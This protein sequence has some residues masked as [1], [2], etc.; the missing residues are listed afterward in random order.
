MAKTVKNKKGYDNKRLSA[1]CLQVSLL[2]NAAIPIPEGLEIMS[3]DASE[4]WERELLKELSEE[5]EIGTPLA[6][7]LEKSGAFPEYLIRMSNIGQQTG[8]LD[9]IMEALSVYY[10]K[11]ARQAE[12][13]KNAITYP[14][15]LVVML[16]VVLYVLFSRVMPVF[17]E[18]YNQLGSSLSPITVT[19]MDFGKTASLVA[20]IAVLV[21]LVLFVV[22]Y[23][24]AKRGI[25][26][27]FVDWIMQT[28]WKRSKTSQSI[29]KRRFAS[30][31]A[32]TLKSGLPMDQGFT[33]AEEVI[34]NADVKEK[35]SKC[36]GLLN[37][38]ENY[39]DVLKS[40]GLF[41]SFHI[42][43]IKVG[44]RSGHLDT[45]M[46][47]ISQDYEEQSEKALNSFVSGFEP[48]VVAILAVC[49]GL[50]LLSVMLPL[51]GLLSSIG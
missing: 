44:S 1:F 38:G 7:A 43:M 22:F 3:E 28:V 5:T 14:A 8:N 21:L 10:D 15:M 6:A 41:S 37:T 9:K 35:I 24:L 39:Y 36:T 25:R 46:E 29:A 12:M 27:G 34:D 19:A 47:A 42:Q 30:V 20:L 33:L 13:L 45:M 31:L 32:L 23:T 17:K 4:D 16:L 26:P 51:A 40:T 2:L 50:V 18:V 48:T 11:E 49:V